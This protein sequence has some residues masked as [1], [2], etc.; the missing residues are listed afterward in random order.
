MTLADR[1]RAEARLIILKALAEPVNE[2]LTSTQLQ[3]ELE[4]FAIR[5]ER[6]WVHTEMRWLAEAGAV[7]LS[8]RGSVLV[9]TLTEM[10]ARH[11]SRDAI[12]ESVLRPSRV[13]EDIVQAGVS[14]AKSRLGG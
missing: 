4:G 9:A 5:R 11:L 7:T 1:I 2:T 8:E 3:L 12:I 13:D 14:L 10:G 6:A